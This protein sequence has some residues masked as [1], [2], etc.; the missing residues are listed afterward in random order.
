MSSLVYRGEGLEVWMTVATWQRRGTAG[1]VATGVS[2]VY[3]HVE[4]YGS[5]GNP[6]MILHALF[7]IRSTVILCD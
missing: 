5:H 7:W 6:K 2:L 4:H 3:I 1:F